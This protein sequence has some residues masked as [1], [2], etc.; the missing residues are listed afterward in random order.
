M[1][2]VNY[3]EVENDSHNSSDSGA[4]TT[5]ASAES[6]P[7]DA[8]PCAIGTQNVYEMV[9]S[10]PSYPPE[11]ATSTTLHSL[12]NPNYARLASLVP[13]YLHGAVKSHDKKAEVSLSF[14]P[15][16]NCSIC[17]SILPNK[18]QYLALQMFGRHVETMGSM[19]YFLEENGSKSIPEPRQRLVGIS[20]DV[21]L[22]KYFGSMLCEG[23]QA[24]TVRTEEISNGLLNL[25]ECVAMVISN[26]AAECAYLYITVATYVGIDVYTQLFED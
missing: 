21:N 19:R 22:F 23:I 26:D 2:P 1:P 15:S 20:T 7:E 8:M 17:L 4:T 13:S 10:P 11:Q 6:Y 12:S 9:Q 3:T 24:S 5:I 14:P 18:V 25:T 16:G